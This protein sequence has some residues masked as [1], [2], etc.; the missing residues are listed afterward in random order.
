MEPLIVILSAGEGSRL[1]PI[2]DDIPKAMIDIGGK[3]L[4]DYKIESLPSG[5]R[6]TILLRDPKQAEKF[7]QLEERLREKHVFDDKNIIYEDMLISLG[8]MPQNSTLSTEELA[9]YLSTFLRSSDSFKEFEPIIFVPVDTIGEGRD[10]SALLEHHTKTKADI[11]ML[12]RKGFNRGSNTR[13]WT[14]EQERFIA[15]SSYL[16]PEWE[17]KGCPPD[18]QVALNHGQEV[19]THEGTYI[20]GINFSRVSLDFFRECYISSDFTE[21]FR[22]LKVVPYITDAEW[23]DIRDITNLEMAIERFGK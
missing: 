6:R 7:R 17:A 16:H 20:V 19:L 1:H 3:P 12:M 21:L 10:Y 9:Y 23:I 15:A 18:M 5:I 11:T 8:Y 14:I 22:T 4:I 2:T 13:I